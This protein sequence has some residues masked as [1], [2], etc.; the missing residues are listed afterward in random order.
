MYIE[1]HAQKA[2]SEM[3]KMFGAILVTGPRQVGKT[4]MLQTMLKDFG[5][6]S[7]D[8]SFNRL[9]ASTKPHTFIKDNPPPVFFDEIQKAPEILSEIKLVLDQTRQKGQY[10]LSGS[11]QFH[12]MKNVSDSLSGRIGILTLPG[13]SLRE[14]LGIGDTTPFL[15][16]PDHLSLRERKNHKISPEEL[17]YMIWRG[18]MPE[19]AANPD[20]NWAV[21]YGSY[22]NTYIERDVKDLSQV[23]DTL[24]FTRF[25]EVIAAHNAQLVNLASIAG[26]TGI[27]QPT[28]DRWLSILTASHIVYLLRP[29]YNNLTKRAVKTPKLYFLDTGLAAYLSHWNTPEALRGGAMSGAYFEAFVISEIIKSYYNCGILEPPVYYYRDRDRKEID[30]LIEHNG[31]IYPCEIKQ[32]A[33][34][35]EKDLK[36]FGILSRIVPGQLGK[37]GLICTYDRPAALT[38]NCTVIPVEYL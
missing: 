11:Q 34:P 26:E 32:H 14:R 27:S 10:F 37:A 15:S 21:Y 23:G 8:D 38:E 30:L 33:D 17:W 36:N 19:M 31:L 1:R 29:Y 35:S 4:T 18:C 20:Y 22:V 7:L 6:I 24:K 5:Y 2:V 25:M 16:T 12:M 3:A 9:N 28:A 13:L